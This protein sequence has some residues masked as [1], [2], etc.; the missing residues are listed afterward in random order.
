MDTYPMNSAKLLHFFLKYGGIVTAQVLIMHYKHS[1]VAGELEIP[2]KFI[3]T[4]ESALIETHKTLLQ[5]KEI[6]LFFF[7]F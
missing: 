2:C 7:Q 3:F 4:S 1:R 5:V 6:S